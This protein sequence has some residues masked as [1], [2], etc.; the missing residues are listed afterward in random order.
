MSLITDEVAQVAVLHVGQDHQWR[1]LWWQTDSQ[2]R[3]D[4][5]VA[6]VLHDDALL[7]ELRHLLQISDA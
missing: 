7:Q 5:G 2:Q 3:E 6:E 1:A 4:I